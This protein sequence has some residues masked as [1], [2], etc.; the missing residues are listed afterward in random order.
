[1]DIYLERKW[2]IGSKLYNICE[3]YHIGEEI[4]RG[5]HGKVYKC[6]HKESNITRAVKLIT[7]D[8]VADYER[9]VTEI[10]VLKDLDH[11]NIVKIIETFECK[12]LCY[13]ILEYYSG[14][15]LFDR[16]LQDRNF[17]E[18][19]AACIM[20]SLL[21]AVSYFHSFKICHRDLNPENCLYISTDPNSDIKIIDFGLSS[22][23][24]ETE[25]LHDVKGSPHYMS[26]EMLE[27]SYSLSADIWSLGV[28]LYLLLSGNPPFTGST[29]EEILLSIYNAS[30]NFRQK[31]FRSVSNPAKELISRMLM[32]DP[33]YRITAEEAL[34][35]RWISGASIP[36]TGILPSEL[37][38]NIDKF[39]KSRKLKKVALMYISSKL[40]EKDI[41]CL[42]ETFKKLDLNSDGFIS[43]DELRLAMN[44]FQNIRDQDL[45]YITNGLDFNFNGLIDYTEFITACLQVQVYTDSGLL[46]S[47]FKFFDKD[48]SGFITLDE[49]KEAIGG[50]DIGINDDSKINE[51]MRE[52][53]KNQDGRIDYSEFLQLMSIRS[54]IP[55]F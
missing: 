40:S 20:K 22:I 1:M 2:F 19:K 5:S 41:G 14:G 13:L 6:T 50:N 7:K 45:E 24:N 10:S 32:K 29:N 16:I 46:K 23:T 55:T 52:A 3:D 43:K 28:I 49:L 37:V 39:V 38:E 33:Q 44:K 26:P 12:R 47:A 35:H 51:M 31:A 8:R 48:Q 54:I 30:L 15:N 42:R 18:Q 53:D 17:S 27:G 4:G 11:P 25:A 34:N 9:F 21:S 36:K